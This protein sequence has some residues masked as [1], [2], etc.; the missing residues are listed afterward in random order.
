MTGGSRRRGAGEEVSPGFR[1]FVAR[2]FGEEGATWLASLPDRLERASARFGLTIGAELPG[3]VLSC[4][5]AVTTRRGEPAVLKLAGS[6]DRPTDEI[7]CLE[8]WAGGGAPRLLAA[9][10]ETGSLLL[11]RVVPGSPATDA[12]ADE[13]AAL[14]RR[15]HVAPL[16]GLPELGDVALRRLARAV[17]Q[18]RVSADRA[19][20]AAERVSLLA[21]DAPE[22]VLLHGDLGRR[23]V[24][25]CA[26]R[27]LVAIDPL[28]CAGDPAYDAACWAHAG[29]R[30]GRRARQLE[31]A[32]A[33]GLDPARVRGWGVVVALHG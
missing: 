30:P 16:R 29:G 22:P 24:L 7:A 17:A 2:T 10:P 1:A 20:R 25:R 5:C 14:L 6:W 8:R 13:V 33:Y 4:V 11:E 28:P 3:G 26:R 27:G 31:I 15:L 23:N 18:Q 19:A 21:V 12:T 32:A 9:E